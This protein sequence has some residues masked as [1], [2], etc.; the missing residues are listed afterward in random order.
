MEMTHGYSVIRNSR[1]SPHKIAI[2]C[3][4]RRRTYRELNERSNRLASSLAKL[5]LQRGDR[6]ATLAFNSVELM[7]SYLAHLKLGLITVPLNA[8]GTDKDILSQAD[9]TGC[10]AFTFTPDF[11]PRVEKFR[12]SLPQ[13]ET[14]ILTGEH[15]APFAH[16]YEDLMARGIPEDFPLDVREGDEAF[17]LFTGGTT[18]IPKGAVLTHKSLLWNVISV[19]T[20]NQSPTPED[21]VYYPMPLFHAAALSRFLACMYAGATFIVTREFDPRTCLEIIAEEKATA[22]TANPTILAKLLQ[23]MEKN[24]S[25][26][27]SM[28]MVLSSQGFLHPT[29]RRAVEDRLFPR[30]GIYVTYALTEAS[31]GV[32]LLKPTDRPRES[33]SVGKPYLC[34]EV[35][36][37]DEQ[38]RDLPAGEVGEILVKGPTVMK[39]Y[40]RNPAETRETLRG[41]W[42]HTGDLGKQDEDGFLYFVDRKKDMIKTGGLNVY[43]REVEEVLSRHPGIAE[44]VIIGVPHETW[45]ETVK[46]VVVPREGVELSEAE[47]IE[48]C[49]ARLASYKKP[50]SVAFVDS[51]PKTPFGGKVL[52]RELRER[53]SRVPGR[54]DPPEKSRRGE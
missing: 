10:R 42:L 38:D 53:F 36:I 25:D 23:E 52:K 29:L 39:E 18:G 9:L 40:F 13:V 45:G 15:S 44:A 2:R 54:F 20:E 24:P 49:K 46:A 5:G 3:G 51:L 17:I 41:G 32:T 50:T 19:T 4:D 1:K 35:R 33:G 30:A 22:M 27:R 34:T 14:W 8:W 31:P 28:R 21:V 7:E 47:I 12:L 16:S 48:F 11:L 43:S 6:V 26:T 37:V